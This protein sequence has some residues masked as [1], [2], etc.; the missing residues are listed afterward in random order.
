MRYDYYYRANGSG[1]Y[2]KFGIIA[3]PWKGLRLGAAIQTP[4]WLNIVEH[5]QERGETKYS[6]KKY[7]ASAESP[8]G[9]Y[10]YHLISPFRVTAGIAYSFSRFALISVDYEMCN[11][12]TMR[13]KGIDESGRWSNEFEYQNQ[14]IKDFMGTSHMIRAGLEIKPV[15]E[16]AIRAGYGLTT[17]PERYFTEFG[18]RKAVKANMHKGSFGLGY[19]SK[20][21]FYADAACSFTKFHN[22]Y[23]M[24]YGDYI[25]NKD[26][27]LEKPSPEIL[28][29]KM[30]WNVMITFGFRF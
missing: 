9:E 5:W 6:D 24:P 2:G 30:L 7:D 21:T 17:S 29:R 3:T 25:F 14:D 28:N 13:F 12:K 18:E 22:E 1:V 8:E 15:P 4:A 19:S 10:R 23:I 27:I 16:F 20:G 11:Y 26:G